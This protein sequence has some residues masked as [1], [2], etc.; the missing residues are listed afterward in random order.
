MPPPLAT[1]ELSAWLRQ[2]QPKE[3]FQ[4]QGDNEG[5]LRLGSIPERELDDWMYQHPELTENDLLRYEY[6]FLSESFMIKCMPLPIHDSLQVFF[7]NNVSVS[8]AQRFGPSQARKLATVASRTTFAG[9]TGDPSGR[10]EKLPDAFVC[11]PRAR[12]PTVVC[13]AGWAEDHEQLVQDARLWLLRTRGETRVVIVLSFRENIPPAPAVVRDDETTTQNTPDEQ[14]L[15]D[16]INDTTV[17]ND[18]ADQ[19]FTLNQEEKL[20]KPLVGNLE[21]SIYV[22]KASEAADDIIETFSTKLLPPPP[23]DLADSS[24]QEFG[25]NLDELFG[26]HVPE[27]QNPK[28]QILFNLADL[29]D[30]VE[31]SITRTELLRATHRAKKLL[32][33]V[34]GA[35]DEETFAQRK[36]RRAEPSC[37]WD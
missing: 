7:T 24:P 4:I 29:Q 2:V 23:T 28:D 32:N 30:C 9:F 27:G 21:A 20:T 3:L 36:R 22:Y 10:S 1:M 15:L 31:E 8:L 14:A 35:D 12:F 5:R 18:L 33:A 34:V 16:S 19:L 17:A 37:S 26:G 6:N 13:E 25:I 11:L